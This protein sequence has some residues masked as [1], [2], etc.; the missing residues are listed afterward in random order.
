MQ[1]GSDNLQDEFF[2]Q[3]TLVLHQS[4][5]FLVTK[6]IILEILFDGIHA[7]IRLPEIYFNLPAHIKLG[8]IPYYFIVFLL[9]STIRVIIIARIALNW[10]STAYEIGKT[11]IKFH[12]GIFHTHEKVFSCAHMHEIEYEQGFLGKLFNFGSIEIHNP[13]IKEKIILYNIPNPK[14]YEQLIKANLT[15]KAESITYQASE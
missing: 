1:K 11:E 10:I 2:L 4:I 7:V 8:L 12:T 9:L 6:I 5:F 13:A 15:T 3:D 14:K